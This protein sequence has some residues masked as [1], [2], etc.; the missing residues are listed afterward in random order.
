MYFI[1]YKMVAKN[2]KK[3]TNIDK[4]IKNDLKTAKMVSKEIYKK[5]SN[6]IRSENKIT[7]YK[8]GSELTDKSYKKFN[9]KYNNDKTNEYMQNMLSNISCEYLSECRDRLKQIDYTYSNTLKI[10]LQPTNQYYSGRCWL[11]AA[12]NSMRH[13]LIAD[14]NVDYDF[15]FSQAHLYYYDKLERCNFFLE[16][17][18][19]LK[20]MDINDPMFRSFIDCNIVNEGGSWTWFRDLI[21]K[22]GVMPLSNYDECFNTFSPDEMNEILTEKLNEFAY[23]LRKMNGNDKKLRNYKDNKMMPEMFKLVTRFMGKPPEKFDWKYNEHSAYDMLGEARVV[24][25]LSAVKFYYD[26]IEP[27]YK[28]DSHIILIHDP[29][30]T[31]E[32]YKT[33]TVQHYGSMVGGKQNIMF[34]VPLDVMKRVASESIKHEQPIW[35]SCDVDK[36]FNYERD[37]L[38]TKAYDFEKTLGTKFNLNKANRMTMGVSYASHAMLLVGVDI[39]HEQ[40][41]NDCDHVNEKYIKWRVENSWGNGSSFQDPGHLQMSDEW[42]SEYVY[43]V[44]VKS[45]YIDTQTMELYDENYDSPIE[46]PFNDPFGNVAF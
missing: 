9:K 39:K 32:Y 3:T 13:R 36:S 15:E 23:T 28:I 42:F 7:L 19:E 8:N 46:L 20:K 30:P 1:K 40:Y 34:N 18:I 10:C 25:D 16:K 33:S 5:L 43:S 22:Y 14:H 17:M 2:R 44:V 45:E 35:F 24:G 29:R 6:R 4:E 12:L 38:D 27:E 37:L 21:K 11:F 41:S 31:S 26:L